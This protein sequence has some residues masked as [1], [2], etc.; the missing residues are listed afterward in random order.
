MKLKNKLEID[1]TLKVG[2][3]PTASTSNFSVLFENEGTISK[4]VVGDIINKNSTDFIQGISNSFPS[5]F[6]YNT[7]TTPSD[8]NL[9]VSFK[10]QL[11][12]T[13]FAAPTTLN[14]TPSFRKLIDSDLS[15]TSIFSQLGNYVPYTGATQNVDL[16]DKLIIT[17][18]TDPDAYF[19]VL[20]FGIFADDPTALGM[21]VETA[22]PILG[23]YNVPYIFDISGSLSNGNNAVTF[24]APNEGGMAF[25]HRNDYFDQ[26]KYQNGRLTLGERWDYVNSTHKLRVKGTGIFTSTLE[27]TGFIRTGSSNNYVLLGGGG[28][29]LVSD[30]ALATDIPDVSNF[31]S[32]NISNTV[33]QD[34]EITSGFG[35]L[36]VGAGNSSA[37]SGEIVGE[38]FINLATDD[39]FA[40]S[41]SM[42]NGNF[43]DAYTSGISGKNL[44]DWYLNQGT[45]ISRMLMPETG[46]TERVLTTGAKIGSNTYYA[47]T[48]GVVELPE[49]PSVN[50]FVPYTGANQPVNLNTQSFSIGGDFEKRNTTFEKSYLT[51][52]T[53]GNTH[54][55]RLT[56][57]AS[58]SRGNDSTTQTDCIVITLP[59]RNYTR[60]VMDVDIIGLSGSSVFG[61]ASTK[62]LISAYNTNNISRGVTA[63]SN[64]DNVKSVSFCRDSNNNTIIIIRPNNNATTSFSYGKVNI[65]NFY[66]GVNYT[67]SLSVKSN[68]KVEAV[69]ESSLTGLTTQGTITNEQFTRD[70]YLWNKGDF[71][72]TN[73][74]NWNTAFGWGDFRTY[75]LGNGSMDVGTW[76]FSVA[77]SG[78]VSA[79]DHSIPGWSS[80]RVWGFKTYYASNYGVAFAM[81][82]NRAAFRTLEAS[83]TGPWHELYHTGNFNPAQYV[84]QSSLNTQ[85]ANYVP[86]NGVTTI[87]NT[88]TFTSSPV[89]PNATLNGHAVNL[90]QVNSLITSNAIQTLSIGTQKGQF[91]ISGGN[92]IKLDSLTTTTGINDNILDFFNS[93]A[94]IIQGHGLKVFR[95]IAGATGVPTTLGGGILFQRNSLNNGGNTLSGSFAL[96]KSNNA[97]NDK[98]YLSTGTGTTTMSDW[99]VIATED[100]VNQQGFSTQTLT[101]GTNIN[102]VGNVISATNTTYSAGTLALLQAGTNTTNRVWSSKVIADYV[103][104][105]IPTNTDGILSYSSANGIIV[106]DWNSFALSEYAISLG[107]GSVTSGNYATSVGGLLSTTGFGS[108]NQGYS[109]SITKALGYSL[110]AYNSVRATLSG[111]FGIGLIN[112]NDGA[113]V[114]GRY[115]SELPVEPYD[116]TSPH[117]QAVFA[118]G[119]GRDETDRYTALTVFGDGRADYTEGYDDSNWTDNTLVTKK[120]VQDNAGGSS[121][122][123][124]GYR[125]VDSSAT[126][127]LSSEYSG[128]VAEN[129]YHIMTSGTVTFI[130]GNA[131]YDEGYKI[132]IMTYSVGAYVVLDSSQGV[133]FIGSSG[134]QI[135]YLDKPNR[136][137]TFIYDKDYESFRVYHVSELLP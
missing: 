95:T 108:T 21:Q 114:V 110:G 51:A 4:R 86:I 55:T 117:K 7:S 106:T 125:N 49:Y 46:S 115:N 82:N 65:A 107:Y 64:A 68:Y 45:G 113:F 16:G 1:S 73:V 14:G 99:R 28:H 120:W 67:S 53:T 13:V 34:F 136:S 118:I 132:T 20:K 102:I 78:F 17:R 57:V 135:S 24:N 131:V 27:S 37:I 58:F 133:K 41:Y 71:T 23:P 79:N 36:R 15:E 3:L 119:A 63:I 61:G 38:S 128:S 72:Q 98:L 66:H 62:L 30:F 123:G 134:S 96:F 11:A 50:G 42:N 112:R 93:E 75:G 9:V 60:W 84:L 70:S 25:R 19:K 39:G 88:K 80:G 56:D 77:Y 8:S 43:F 12:G 121:G 22:N 109:N 94:N 124:V 89:V 6:N 85:L 10:N 83:T 122:G 127:D 54:F 69:L 91:S 32:K 76:N 74:D 90:G 81:R 59:I 101:A 126:F 40:V 5:I 48:Q 87:N 18:T 29:K 47:N 44:Y 116:T 105:M 129:V 130:G 35:T 137:V 97:D 104:S 26:L 111:A 33:T 100:W 92:S 31:L 2:A 52:S 103:T